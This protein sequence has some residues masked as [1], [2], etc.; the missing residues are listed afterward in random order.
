M[1]FKKSEQ[2]AAAELAL[3]ILY[4]PRSE[5][6]QTSMVGVVQSQ[7]SESRA[8]HRTAITGPQK[9]GTG[10][11]LISAWKE[12]RD[13]G[14]PPIRLTSLSTSDVTKNFTAYVMTMS[15]TQLLL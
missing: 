4:K 1:E 2:S 6:R 10:G 12:C 3:G 8:T 14:H 7:V 9:R 5:F 11:T 15:W 13:Q